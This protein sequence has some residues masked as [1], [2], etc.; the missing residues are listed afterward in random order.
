MHPSGRLCLW[1]L[2]KNHPLIAQIALISYQF[3]IPI[4]RK[5]VL[6]EDKLFRKICWML[7]ESLMIE[8]KSVVIRHCPIMHSISTWSCGFC[9]PSSNWFS[10]TNVNTTI[11]T[12]RLLL[13][14]KDKLFCKTLKIY[15]RDLNYLVA[16][17]ESLKANEG[18]NEINEDDARIE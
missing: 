12:L 2:I 4:L 16:P 9:S 15:L 5:I 10:V 8:T 17:L 14:V 18:A 11:K 13:L 3:I 6:K 7:L 1:Y